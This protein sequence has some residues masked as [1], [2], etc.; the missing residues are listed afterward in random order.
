MR[1][2]SILRKESCFHRAHALEGIELLDHFHSR[3]IEP[4]KDQKIALLT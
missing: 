2:G 4:L 3:Q 1:F